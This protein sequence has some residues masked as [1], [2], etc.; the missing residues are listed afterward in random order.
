MESALL[1]LL[2]ILVVA[3]GLL[4]SIGL[5]E[6]GHLLPAKL[7]G[8]KVSQFMIGFGPTLFSRRR[9]E[10]VYGVRA[11][12]LGG[13]VSMAGMYPPAKPGGAPRDADTGFLTQVLPSPEGPLP[14]DTHARRGAFA[15]LADDARIASHAGLEPGEEHRVFYR[16]P[17][18]KRIIVMLGGP[19]MNLLLAIL[20]YGIL[21]SGLGVAQLTTTIGVVNEC[22]V[23]ASSEQDGCTAADPLAPAAEAGILPGD[24]IQSIDGVA[25]SSWEQ[26]SR[27]IRVADGRPLPV[28]VERDGRSIEL[29]VTPLLAERYATDA[30][31]RILED[32]AGEPLTEQVGFVGIG[33]TAEIARQ[34]VT[35]VPPA[36]WD[37]T[38]AVGRIILTLPQRLI[39]VGYAAFGSQER[40]PN[41]PISL[42]GVGRLAG[43]ITSNEA[44][45]VDDRARTLIGVLAAVNV[46]LFVFNLLPLLPLDGGH[47]AGALFEA[48]RRRIAMLRGRPDPGP[49]DT[50]RFIPLTLAVVLVFGASTVLLIYADIVNPIAIF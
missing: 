44:L 4:L 6:V 32:A 37:N 29:T 7:F 20:F 23:P 15:S 3:V 11:L 39:D 35:E 12:P 9:G 17:V 50:A 45:A 8:V 42:V 26:I 5:H 14:G 21:L 31:G 27:A 22:V 43:E 33:P 10:T 30:Q 1:Y 38:V 49:I 18:W 25:I 13:Y 36:V 46:A 16:L 40:D 19:A 48:A 24:R 2:G 47:I 28:T 34:P 41:G